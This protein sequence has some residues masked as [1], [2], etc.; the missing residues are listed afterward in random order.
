MKILFMHINIIATV[1]LVI[2]ALCLESDIALKIC[3]VSTAYI[4]LY[5]FRREILKAIYKVFCFYADALK[6]AKASRMQ[7]AK[8]KMQ[9]CGGFSD[10]KL[11]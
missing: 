1:V 3:L 11:H 5:T 4:A 7:N 9:N 6:E 2:S 10:E 8:C